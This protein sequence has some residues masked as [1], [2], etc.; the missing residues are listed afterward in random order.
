MRKT[1]KLHNCIIVQGILPRAINLP[2]EAAACTVF[3]VFQDVHNA[4]E[5]FVYIL[6]SSCENPVANTRSQAGSLQTALFPR[7][8][9]GHKLCRSK[10]LGD[11]ERIRLQ[12]YYTRAKVP[13]GQLLYYQL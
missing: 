2:V 11:V 13:R 3:H 8:D 5:A 4:P 7:E 10:A 6:V 9:D 1:A 12:R